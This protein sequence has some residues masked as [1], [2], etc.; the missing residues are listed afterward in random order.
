VTGKLPIKHG[1]DPWGVSVEGR[2]AT[3]LTQED[4]RALVSRR[5]GRYIHGS[6]SD[7]RVSPAYFHTLGIELLSG[8]LLDERD[9]V[10]VPMVAVVNETFSRK[11]FP[12]GDPVGKRVT[13]NYTSW[14]PQITIV[15]VVADVKLNRLDKEPNPEMFWAMSQAPSANVWLAIRTSIDPLALAAAVQQTVRQIDSDLPILELDSMEGVIADSLWRP[16][17]SALLIG[18]FALLALVLAAA[19]I[20]GVMSYSVSQRTHEVGLRMALG[21]DGR[22]ILAMIIGQGLK[23]TLAGVLIGIAA[24]LALGRLVASQLYQISAYDPLTLIGVST[25]LMV[26]ALLACYLPARRAT[27]VDPMVA[28]SAG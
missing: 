5:T 21:A 23:L 14:F 11:F 10:G 20:Y 9:T 19:G 12:D 1:F 4:G 18:L 6:T 17:F 27:K 25:F 2:G 13:V 3:L 22:A 28:L 16:R 15:G 8:R 7:Q 26:V 24:S